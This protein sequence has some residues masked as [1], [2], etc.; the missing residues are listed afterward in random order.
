MSKLP[1]GRGLVQSYCETE[2]EVV[3]L[4]TVPLEEMTWLGIGLGPDVS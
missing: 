2:E 1:G 3:A 4:V